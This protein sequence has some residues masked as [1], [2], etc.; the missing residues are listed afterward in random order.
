LWFQFSTL[1]S[2]GTSAT[3]DARAPVDVCY[4]RLQKKNTA[5][6]AITVLR[7][8][9]KIFF[10]SAR[11]T[12]VNRFEELDSSSALEAQGNFSKVDRRSSAFCDS[13]EIIGADQEK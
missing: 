4:L 10:A 9:T 7:S 8:R 12:Q 6:K 1:I 5:K 3:L 11:C 13:Q 2:D